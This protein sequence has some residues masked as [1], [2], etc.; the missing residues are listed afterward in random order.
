MDEQ[1][2]DASSGHGG[3]CIGLVEI[4][5]VTML[6]V[7]KGGFNAQSP[8]CSAGPSCTDAVVCQFSNAGEWRVSYHC[9]EPI[10]RG[11]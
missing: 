11:Q 9:A 8:D 5:T 1:D 10:L 6:C 3:T 7:G 2:R 4:N